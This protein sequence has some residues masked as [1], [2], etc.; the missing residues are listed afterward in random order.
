N[1]PPFRPD[2]VA[3]VDVPSFICK[4]GAYLFQISLRFVSG[5]QRNIYRAYEDIICCRNQLNEAF[6]HATAPLKLARVSMHSSSMLYLN[7]AIAERR[8]NE[9]DEYV[10]GLLSMPDEVV[11]SPAVQKLF[12]SRAGPLPDAFHHGVASTPASAS[13]TDTAVDAHHAAFAGPAYKAKT[14]SCD[15]RVA[16]IAEPAPAALH[17]QLAHKASVSALG[18]ACATVKVKVKLGDD[19]VAL[20]L[21]SE[22]TLQ[23][24]KARIAMRVCGG[25]TTHSADSISQIVYCAPSGESAPLSDDQDWADALL[26]TNNKPV[27]TIVQ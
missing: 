26:A 15:S 5:D 18:G 17:R 11:A 8:R 22:L 24:L 1:F 16:P 20:R 23:E 3:A 27:L 13:S 7:D 6:P 21:P 12:G 25:E 2:E 19:M 10:G 4:D 9:I 14:M